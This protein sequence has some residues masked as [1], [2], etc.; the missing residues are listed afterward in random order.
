MDINKVL[1]EYYPQNYSDKV[2]K[3]SEE[4]GVKES[5]VY[6]VI[7]TESGFRAEV[8][9]SVGAMGLMQIM[10]IVGKQFNVAKEHIVDPE[11]NIRLAGKLLKQIEKILKLSP[12]TSA[13]DRM[14][15]I[16]ACY[17]GGIGHVTDARRLA[18][19]NGEDPNSWEV[20]ARYLKLK[21]DPEIYQS[22]LV[23]HGRFTGS[24]QTIAY[25]RE[26]MQRYD[27]YRLVVDHNE[28][29]M[30]QDASRVM[31]NLKSLAR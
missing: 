3:Y 24:R 1:M 7:R 29:L 30:A 6:A 15:I 5:L 17:N 23:R 13:N 28:A 19:S 27:H 31:R 26:V 11:T 12:T 25:V 21:A 8:E 2:E 9:S 14:S 18:K 16:L 10:P 22:D 20:V 4:Y